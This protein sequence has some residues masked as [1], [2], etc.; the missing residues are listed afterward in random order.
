MSD[1]PVVGGEVTESARVA[2]EDFGAVLHVSSNATKSIAENH[3]VSD[4]TFRRRVA[5]T[6]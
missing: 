1:A 3:E 2:F 6:P 5:D 4:V